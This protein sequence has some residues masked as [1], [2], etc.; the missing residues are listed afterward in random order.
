MRI[1]VISAGTSTPSS[2]RVLADR[3]AAAVGR[4][5]DD[6]PVV[7]LVELRELAHPLVDA[8]LT[9]FAAGP[10]RAAV[11][12]VERADGIVVVT[13]V[14]S[15]S[16]SALLKAFVDVLDRDALAGVP[17]LIG[18]TGGSERHSLVLEHAVRPLFT[19][20]HA[21]VVPT[22]VY[23]ATSDFGRAADGA[24]LPDR[25]ARAA[26]ELASLVAARRPTRVDHRAEPVAF[27][28]LL[29]G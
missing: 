19:Y 14:H 21:L 7:D 15:A 28:E 22:A 16:Y 10:L 6:E 8:L 23:A 13:P 18:A 29:A 3:L 11:D 12:L 25:I 9:G 17:V 20:L 4:S 26:D 27:A 2:T 5:F 1:A 24:G